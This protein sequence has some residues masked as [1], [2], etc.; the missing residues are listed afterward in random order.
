MPP[1]RAVLFDFD[2]TLADSFPAITASVNHVRDLYGLAPLPVVEVVVHV[3]R[4]P[5]YL[6][7]K[8]VPGGDS[9]QD[10]RRYLAHHPQIM[11]SLTTLMPGATRLV[12]HLRQDGVELGVCSN[13]PVA[14]TRELLAHLN[15]A[16]RFAVVLGPEDVDRPKPAPDMLVA[17]AG[18]LGMACEKILYVGDSRTDIAAARA[19]GMPIWVV[20]TGSDAKVALEQGRPDR[21]FADLDAIADAW[22]A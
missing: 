13:K 3:G 19:A 10:C 21:L 5:A 17:A 15:V 20:P 1:F 18:Q 8:T 9:A 4:G 14:F 7:S 22:A 12:E 11:R 2:G 6:L 16:E